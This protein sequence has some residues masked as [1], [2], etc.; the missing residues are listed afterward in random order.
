MKQGRGRGPVS[1]SRGRTCGTDLFWG[2]GM[3]VATEKAPRG[4]R[5]AGNRIF[6]GSLRA[7]EGPRSRQ[8][9]LYLQLWGEEM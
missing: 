2:W 6:R 8:G 5:P 4:R 7:C 9:L 1:V 3:E